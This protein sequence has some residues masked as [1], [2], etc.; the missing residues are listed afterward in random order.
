[1]GALNTQGITKKNSELINKAVLQELENKVNKELKYLGLSY[2]QL[3]LRSRG[4]K[5]ITS[6]RLQFSKSTYPRN[7]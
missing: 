3:N 4:S 2:L 5:G 6:H 1:M 7:F